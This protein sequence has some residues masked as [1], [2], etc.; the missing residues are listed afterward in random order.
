MPHESF[1]V[2][3]AD[4]A[5]TVGRALVSSLAPTEY[6]VRALVTTAAQEPAA[7]RAGADDVA[8]AALPPADAS[9]T[10]DG[11]LAD[12]VAGVD[13]ICCTVR[14][15]ARGLLTGR[16]TAGIG[17]RALVDAVADATPYVVLHSRIG[18]DDSR[19]AL[20]LPRR[21]LTYRLRTAYARTE[22]HLRETGLPHTIVRTGRVTSDGSRAHAVESSGDS[23]DRDDRTRRDIAVDAAVFRDRS[24]GPDTFSAD[25]GDRTGAR[26]AALVDPRHDHDVVTT[27]GADAVDAPISTRDLAWVMAAALTTPAVRNRTFEVV[28]ADATTI[29]G[30]DLDWRGPETGFVARRSG[31]SIP[32]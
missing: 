24:N 10:P 5:T 9:S 28:D 2:L 7:T 25:D 19:H 32:S 12:A 17:V 1:R 22:R 21:L 8:V 16:L 13:A 6:E 23:S 14:D 4:A 18:V 15:H 30:L 3:V 20:S 11:A 29:A 31:Y 26:D 27:A